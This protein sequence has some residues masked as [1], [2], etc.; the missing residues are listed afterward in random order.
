MVLCTVVIYNLPRFEQPQAVDME[1]YTQDFGNHYHFTLEQLLKG[2]KVHH[3]QLGNSE[4]DEQLF[5]A[6]RQEV[7]LLAKSK[8]TTK[9]ICFTFNKATNYQRFMDA[10]D[11]CF[12]ENVLYVY[13]KDDLWI[14]N[15][16]IQNPRNTHFFSSY[17]YYRMKEE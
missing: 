16:S 12:I 17:A 4:R 13:Y 10:F 9:V 8:D 11:T 3:Y 14:M 6:Y 5:K 7:R 15:K 1:L 2:K